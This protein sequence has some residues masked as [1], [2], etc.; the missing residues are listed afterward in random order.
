[1]FNHLNARFTQ[2][3][4]TK[5]EISRNNK[6][7]T[8]NRIF[9]VPRLLLG[10]VFIKNKLSYETVKNNQTNYQSGNSFT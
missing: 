7:E 9:K 6:S 1:M 5:S 4:V 3:H 8:L 2:N 10:S